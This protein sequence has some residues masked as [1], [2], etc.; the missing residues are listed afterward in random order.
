[1]KKYFLL[2]LWTIITFI[3]GI[4]GVS[5]KEN[6]ELINIE[7]Y[8][9]SDYVEINEDVTI[10]E[11]EIIS[12]VNFYDE[13]DYITYKLTIKNNNDKNYTIKE[14]TDN[15]E[16]EYLEIE[17]DYDEYL[18]AE[19]EKEILLKITY[20]SLLPYD[21]TLTP[22]NVFNAI[23]DIAISMNL[24]EEIKNPNTLDSIY[25]VLIIISLSVIAFLFTTKKLKKNYL[26]LLLL[27]ALLLPKYINAESNEIMNFTLK[28]TMNMKVNFLDKNWYKKVTGS[29]S[30]IEFIKEIELPDEAVDV[31]EKQDETIKAW[32]EDGKVYIG[33]K[34][35]IF[36]PKNSY[37]LL[38]GSH[39]SEIEFNNR[40]DTTFVTD[41]SYL[42]Q[43]DTLEKIDL[44]SFR[45]GNVTTTASMFYGNS[46]IT[47]L[48]LSDLDMSKV[49]N[50]SGMLCSC[51]KLEKITIDNWNLSSMTQGNGYFVDY[52]SLKTISAINLI[53][54]AN[55]EQFF[56]ANGSNQHLE[57]IDLTGSDTSNTTNMYSMFQ[58]QVFLK[59]IKG[60]DKWDTSKVTN[61]GYM[62]FNVGYAVN[63]GNI[64]LDLSG[65]DI[66]NVEDMTLALYKVGYSADEVNLTINDWTNDKL[67]SVAE[68]FRNVGCYSDNVSVVVN[69]FNVSK[70][71]DAN[72]LFLEI[73][74]NAKNVTIEIDGL[75][76]ENAKTTRY[77]F[78]SVG[79]YA[80][81]LKLS[82]ANVNMP[83][84][85]DVFHIFSYTGSNAGEVEINV[86]N[87][88]FRDLVEARELFY[89]LGSS[90]DKV[91]FNF[92]NWELPN[93]TSM[94]L[95]FYG[96]GGYSEDVSFNISG[97]DTSKLDYGASMFK[98][99]GRSSKNVAISGLDKIDFSKT[100]DMYNFFECSFSATD[101][102]VDIGT[103]DVY[104]NDISYA[105]HSSKSVK[106]TLNLHTKP[107]S[108]MFAFSEAATNEGSE[109]IVNYTADVTNIDDIINTKSANSNVIKGHLIEE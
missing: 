28:N 24:E 26:F 99:I 73:G 101:N 9:K 93:A 38:S 109:I 78:E 33:S 70:A 6:I 53:F 97:L 10:K 67:T 27:P 104:A 15:N 107:S 102:I 64:S 77:M 68:V 82:V 39:I 5:A 57:S 51:P 61:M 54:P 71:T 95:M 55:S 20:R 59:E 96:I 36:F 1:M 63:G 42:F 7:L 18:K 52:T 66:S 76:L 103:I 41:M 19:E 100:T 23:N 13:G 98:N 92:S 108:Y 85:T 3:I 16:S 49:T 44:S 79:E 35:R 65:W 48:D 11:N 43:N 75:N 88:K 17:Y 12:N 90:A 34:Y 14:I 62:L 87:W 60:I 56:R 37:Q 83:S 58:N 91:T 74:S 80:E 8:E 105:F 50:I 32:V 81:N 89:Y 40:I 84:V 4:Y 25:I 29:Y 94:A 45:T 69:N 47:E 2:S 46:K 30:K 106:V 21:A 72:N 22:E 31:S 86:D